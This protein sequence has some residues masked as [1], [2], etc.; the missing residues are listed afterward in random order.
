MHL[1]TR[2]DRVRS[3]DTSVGTEDAVDAPIGAEDAADVPTGAAAD[4]PPPCEPPGTEV[5]PHPFQAQAETDRCAVR[6]TLDG[7]VGAFEELVRRYQ[8]RLLAFGGRFFRNRDDAEDFVQE[9][10]LRAF[11]KLATFRGEGRF[12]SWLMGIAYNLA[13]RTADVRPRD[14]SIEGVDVVSTEASPG[15][16]AIRNDVAQA[17]A[18]AVRALPRR[19]GVCVDLFF[20]FGM[21][22]Q[23]IS[24]T[25][26][27]RLNTVRSHIRRGKIILKE[28]LARTV[29]G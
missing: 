23:E 1:P 26:G 20:V 9:V 10:F 25:T 16:I 27:F 18:A 24:D 4:L 17:V 7:D 28:Q 13:V 29:G 15:E 3:P 11:R 5:A 22:Y 14:R 12:Y 6:K 21:S 2:H 19:Y 8:R